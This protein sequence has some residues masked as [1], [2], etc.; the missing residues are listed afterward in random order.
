MEY[1]VD[2]TLILE[3]IFQ[4]SLLDQLEG[5]VTE[6]RVVYGFYCSDE[7]Q[8]I[9]TMQSWYSLGPWQD[10]FAEDNAVNEIES[11]KR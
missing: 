9:F 7:K 11:D 1:I 3:A 4:V 8:R 6:D 5:K 10:P 2:L